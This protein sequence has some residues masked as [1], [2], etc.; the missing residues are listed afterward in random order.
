MAGEGGVSI[1]V[2]RSHIGLIKPR[3][4]RLVS[5]T[6]QPPTRRGLRV[7]DAIMMSSGN[8]YDVIMMSF[9]CKIICT[10][11]VC[12]DAVL[13][14]LVTEAN[15]FHSNR[16]EKHF[17]SSC[18]YNVMNLCSSM[19]LI[20]LVLVCLCDSVR[21]TCDWCSLFHRLSLRASL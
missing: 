11:N 4:P 3:Y 2:G 13:P 8:I 10:D 20:A 9:E 5:G 16:G 6:T 7:H 19:L 15:P 14:L 1:L 17:H 18:K 21:Q 12:R